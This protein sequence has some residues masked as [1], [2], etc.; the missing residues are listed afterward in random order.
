M[1]K[2]LPTSNIFYLTICCIFLA[3]LALSAVFTA[4]GFPI[5]L[6]VAVLVSFAWGISI[7]RKWRTGNILCMLIFVLGISLGAIL[8]GSR[9]ILLLS[10]LSTMASWDLAAFFSRLSTDA[11]ISNENELIRTHLFRLMSV[12]I[13]GVVLSLLALSMQIDLKFWQVFLL[14]IL[15]LLGL[16]QLFA[17]LKRSNN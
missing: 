7:W 12:L 10:L 2:R 6:V 5:G 14:G 11:N 17:Q 8:E 3:S 15:L 13:I 4:V 16:S 1:L 9:Y